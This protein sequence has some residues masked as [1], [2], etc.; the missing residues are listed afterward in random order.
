[1]RKILAMSL[2]LVMALFFIACGG[3]ELAPEQEIV[4]GAIQALDDI[5]TY[6]FEMDMALDMAAES[7]GETFAVTMEADYSGALDLDNQQMRLY[8]TMNVAMPEEETV[9]GAMELYLVDGTGYTMMDVPETDP[10]WEKEE[11]SEADWEGV[12]EA[13]ML[14][15]PYLELLEASEVEVIGSESV[16]G[17]DCY[18]LQLTPDLA[19]LW[20]TAGQQ[21]ALGFTEEMGWPDLS[22]EVLD[23]ASPSFSVKQW[24]AK[25]TYFLMKVD[26]DMD[27]ELTPEVMGM[28]EEE[29]VATI[30]IVM[31]ML[32]Y[33]YNQPVS[34]ELP[35]EAKE[36]TES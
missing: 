11:I 13:L 30:A 5:R 23:A 16:Q 22:A 19:Q 28:P 2:V 6:E 7:E 1:M 17:V 8:M 33:N 10:A 18:V 3:G 12:I 25:D 34:I 32:A 21:A 9:E 15:K 31:K 36:A 29:G 35:P 20:E 14:A 24:V 4:D 27:L 26:I